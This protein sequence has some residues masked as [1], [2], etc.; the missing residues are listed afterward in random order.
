[1]VGHLEPSREKLPENKR[2]NDRQQENPYIQKALPVVG[3]N[4]SGFGRFGWRLG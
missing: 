2:H 1:M 3:G 4:F